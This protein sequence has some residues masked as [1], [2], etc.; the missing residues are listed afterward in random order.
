MELEVGIGGPGAVEGQQSMF[1]EGGVQ[2]DGL[3]LPSPSTHHKHV[4]D[5]AI[6]PFAMVAD[7]FQIGVQVRTYFLDLFLVY[8]VFFQY[9]LQ[10]LQEFL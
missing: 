8:L 9:F 5:D 4:L 6:G 10:L 2:L 3:P 1:V 7:P